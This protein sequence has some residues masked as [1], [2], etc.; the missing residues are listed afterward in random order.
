MSDYLD[1]PTLRQQY[2]SSEGLHRIL[3]TMLE[4]YPQLREFQKG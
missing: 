4:H 1:I 3:S 2:P